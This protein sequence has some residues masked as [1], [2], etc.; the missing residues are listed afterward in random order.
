MAERNDDLNSN[1]SSLQAGSALGRRISIARYRDNEGQKG[2]LSPAL[3]INYDPITDEHVIKYDDDGKEESVALNRQVFRWICQPSVEV[4]EKQSKELREFKEGSRL[5]AR[6]RSLIGRI[7]EYTTHKGKKKVFEIKDY[8][9]VNGTHQIFSRN[10][11]KLKNIQMDKLK[12]FRWIDVIAVLPGAKHRETRL[13]SSKYIGVQLPDKVHTGFI[14]LAPEKKGGRRGKYV[15]LF[16]SAK[17]AALVHDCFARKVG[18]D[19]EELNFK[20][21]AIDEIEVEKRRKV[22]YGKTLP[23]R[24]R[25]QYRGVHWQKNRKRW[26]ARYSKNGEGKKHIN[27]GAFL[28]AEHAALA[29]DHEARKQGREDEALNFPERRVTDEQL[30]EWSTNKDH[31]RHM[32]SGIEKSSQF[33]GVTNPQYNRPSGPYPW[34]AQVNIQKVLKGLGIP[35]SQPAHL[36]RYDNELQAALA[37]DRACRNFGVKE[38]G[39]NFPRNTPLPEVRLFDSSCHYCNKEE[40]IDPVATTCNHV[41]C[42]RCIIEYLCEVEGC[43]CCQTH[44]TAND[45]SLRP[46]P[47]QKWNNTGRSKYHFFD[48]RN[49]SINFSNENEAITSVNDDKTR[50]QQENQSLLQVP[51]LA[52][53]YGKGSQ[54]SNLREESKTRKSSDI[55]RSEEEDDC[56]G[57]LRS[58]VRSKRTKKRKRLMKRR[59]TSQNLIKLEKDDDEK[60]NNR[61]SNCGGSL[62]KSHEFNTEMKDFKLKKL[63]VNAL[64]LPSTKDQGEAYTLCMKRRK[65]RTLSNQ[66][67]RGKSFDPQL[68][69]D[70]ESSKK[71]RKGEGK[72]MEANESANAGAKAF[73]HRK[74]YD[75]SKLKVGD[76]TAF[77]F[78]TDIYFGSIEKC[79]TNEKSKTSWSWEVIFDDGEVYRFDQKEM[80]EGTRIYENLKEKE[81]GDPLRGERLRKMKE[82]FLLKKESV[83]SK[84][85]AKVQAEFM[86]VGFARWCDDFHPVLF[87]SPYDIS[88]G[89]VREKWLSELKKVR[90]SVN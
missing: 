46:V 56:I 45:K 63:S 8:D 36:G 52:S 58:K 41:F 64:N 43:P 9:R 29:F 85:P 22:D 67:E 18:C 62:D 5:E 31:Y 60:K 6:E 35:L 78:G 14:A 88:P 26:M 16:T 42:R 24:G 51:L 1:M 50:V 49:S 17:D 65:T 68:S 30:Q 28:E 75:L 7:F 38:V 15:G 54:T 13:Y 20:Y 77:D 40:A 83:L 47:L 72:R 74:L 44:M 59:G 39:L 33:R 23:S 82:D 87:C 71:S 76:R 19:P 3:V 32:R 55:G 84:I 79:F 37:F 70:V 81:L 12:N 34:V 89:Q 27:L 2:N 11:K 21:E 25:S 4:K 69:T 57:L 61:E 90:M 73:S 10:S 53:D 80:M 66:K 86:Q 48:D